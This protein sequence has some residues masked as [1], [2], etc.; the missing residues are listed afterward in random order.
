MTD[1]KVNLI[2]SL[3][4]GVSSGLQKMRENTNA[5]GESFKK[6]GQIA[7]TYLTFRAAIGGIKAVIKAYSDAESVQ[8]RLSST[9]RALGEQGTAAVAKWGAFATSVQ[10][11][12]TLGDEQVMSLVTMAKTMGVAN[13]EIANT[14]KGAIALSKAFGIDLGTSMK[15][16][17]LAGEGQYEMLARYIPALKTAT[18][19]TQ[20]MAIVNQAMAVGWKVAGEELSTVKGA[21][22]SLKESF[23]DALEEIGKS[24][25]GDGGLVAGLKA[26]KE[27]INELIEGG[28]IKKW[29][30]QAKEAFDAIVD[31]IK[32]IADPKTR[33]VAIG[34]V[35]AL[36]KA[37]FLESAIHAGKYLISVAPTIGHDIG[38][39]AKA[40]MKEL[41]VN[42]K[43]DAAAHAVQKEIGNEAYMNLSGAERK[44]AIEKKYRENLKAEGA[45]NA[46]EWASGFVRTGA[47]TAAIKTQ[48]ADKKAADQK[49]AL[50]ARESYEDFLK[51][52]NNPTKDAGVEALK[53]QNAANQNVT[54]AVEDG[55]NTTKT[56]LLEVKKAIVDGTETFKLSGDKSTANSGTPPPKVTPPP[57]PP[58]PPPP[59]PTSKPPPKPPPT[60]T[61]GIPQIRSQGGVP[62]NSGAGGTYFNL[63]GTKEQ[64][65]K[66][67]KRELGAIQNPSLKVSGIRAG[68]SKNMD[69][70]GEHTKKTKIAHL[71]EL[72]RYIT[73]GNKN[74]QSAWT[75][76]KSPLAEL[77][78][79]TDE[80]TEYLKTISERVGGVKG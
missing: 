15:L 31:T 58:P 55:A 6:L 39:A 56:A 61:D 46:D 25:F 35:T 62:Q 71:E 68:F 4:D 49:A 10:R 41:F 70:F 21:W 22:A 78:K 1:K 59:T 38:Q 23:G 33:E 9:F 27:K 47:A 17:V 30:D 40:A 14:T 48:I 3:K 11:S 65:L 63:S 64:Q 54:S 13:N 66:W 69:D 51:R 74:V 37:A 24:F 72:I 2:I 34:N 76:E 28:T 57:T 26:A 52:V 12:T 43:G 77:S 32:L 8:N 80:Q 36:L 79:K 53:A 67:A 29:A 75:G 60:P 7:A 50:G 18:T 42:S 73:T 16:T 5:V 19:D 44:A 45:A 20:K